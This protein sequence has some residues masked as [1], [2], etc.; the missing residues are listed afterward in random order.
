MSM[1]IDAHAVPVWRR[2][3]RVNFR[4]CVRALG[5]LFVARLQHLHRFRSNEAKTPKNAADDTGLALRH[6]TPSSL[7]VTSIGALSG[8]TEQG[9][10]QDANGG[11][12]GD[13]N[14]RGWL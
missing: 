3:G 6:C 5:R 9:P 4:I 7:I 1:P 14:D 12:A 13:D 2:S 8:V 11:W 10:A